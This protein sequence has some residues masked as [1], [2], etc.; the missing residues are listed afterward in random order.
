MEIAVGVALGAHMRNHKRIHCVAQCGVG[1]EA[2]D[3]G[4]MWLI[5][6]SWSVDWMRF[7]PCGG[8][9]NSGGHDECGLV[10]ALWWFECG[11]AVVL[12]SGE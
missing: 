2:V 10:V 12:V 9:V 11:F 7:V 8:Y 4:Y 3:G 1:G 6:V 5:A